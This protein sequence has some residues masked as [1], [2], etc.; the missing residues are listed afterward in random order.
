VCVCVCV[1]K[2]NIYIIHDYLHQK[3]VCFVPFRVVEVSCKL[4]EDTFAAEKTGPY[5]YSSSTNEIRQILSLFENRI[6]KRNAAQQN[7]KEL[8]FT[9]E[10]S[11]STNYTDTIENLLLGNGWFIQLTRSTL[12][13]PWIRENLK[14]YMNVK[15][16]KVWTYNYFLLHFYIATFFAYRLKKKIN[17]FLKTRIIFEIFS[18]YLLNWY[19]SVLE[20][21]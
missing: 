12:S 7:N 5:N 21:K 18:K 15:Y 3:F 14:L 16:N 10:S 2:I 13:D 17:K 8:F 4:R 6:G 9:V 19:K 1:C 11:K 20:N